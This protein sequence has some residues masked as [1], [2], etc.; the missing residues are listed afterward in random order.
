MAE[1]EKKE[2]IKSSQLNRINFIATLLKTKF[3]PQSTQSFFRHTWFYKNAKFAK[4]GIEPAL[5]TLRL[6]THSIIKKT[7][8]SL[9]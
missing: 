8:R 2:T 1:K 6:S 3:L 7:L 4:L 9:R 5:R